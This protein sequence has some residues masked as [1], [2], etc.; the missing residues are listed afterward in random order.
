MPF[1]WFIL[2][3]GYF[4]P[5]TTFRGI[6]VTTFRSDD[7]KDSMFLWGLKQALAVYN[8]WFKGLKFKLLEGQSCYYEERHIPSNPIFPSFGFVAGVIVLIEDPNLSLKECDF[9]ILTALFQGQFPYRPLHLFSPVFTKMKVCD[10]LFADPSSNHYWNWM[11]ASHRP[12]FI[13]DFLCVKSYHYAE[14]KLQPLK[15]I[16]NVQ[17]YRLFKE[18]NFNFVEYFF[19]K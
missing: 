2:S 14:T 7:F 3:L 18:A 5:L 6:S 15:Y 17:F 11:V 9:N 4:R 12:R 19:I 8:F 1:S 16:K 13:P 10:S